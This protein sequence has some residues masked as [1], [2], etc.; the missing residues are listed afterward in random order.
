MKPARDIAALIEI[1]AAL[2]TPATGC[3]WDLAQN[4]ASIAPYIIEEAYEVAHAITLGDLDDLREELGDLLF[5]VVF[6]ARLAQ[7]EG[8]FNFADVVETITAKMIRRHPH[9]FD[10]PRRLTLASVKALSD[11]IKAKEKE[12]RAR[13]RGADHNEVEGALIGVPASLPALT[14][15]LKL[16][17]KASKA[18]FDRHD[19]KV[20]LAKIRKQADE[21][22][23]TIAAGQKSDT[24]A[25]LGDLVFATVNL[26]RHLNADPES[27]LRAA[28]RRFEQRFAQVERA[29]ARGESRREVHLSELD[30]LWDSAKLTETR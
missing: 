10:E 22:E 9:V 24:G 17:Q 4:F 5:H 6:Q 25:E 23:A 20:V 8:A 11:E 13:R 1:I 26:A 2:R 18:G 7:E 12:E 19:P 3:P 28:N 30:Q 14:R 16:Q 29:R 21:I 27:V 15:T